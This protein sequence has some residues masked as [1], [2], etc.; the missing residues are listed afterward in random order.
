MTEHPFVPLIDVEL[1]DA[2]RDPAKSDRGPSA[3]TM[4]KW[5]AAA[6]QLH[7]AS[8]SSPEFYADAA[9]FAVDAI[10][11][12]A[13]WV[14]K[15]SPHEATTWEVLGS[16]T[17]DAIQ[18][19]NVPPA[20]L[21]I[22][23][24]QPVTWFQPAP[25]ES[26]N[27]GAAP[28]QAAVVSPVLDEGGEIAAVVY[29]V[30]STQAANRR[31]G[32]R[33]LEARLMQL[34]AESVSVGIRRLEQETAAARSRILL[35]QAFSPTVVEHLEKHPQCLTGQH[36]EVTLLFADLCSFTALAEPLSPADCY[37]LLG[38][39]METLTQ[40]VNAECGIVV[41][42]YGDGL[43]AL[44]NAPLAQ[45]EHADAACRAAL[46]MLRAFAALKKKWQP[47]LRGPLELG[48]GV[49]TGA[50][51]VGNAG[52]RTRLKYGP[53]GSTVNLAHRVQSASKQLALP[54]VVSGATQQ[55]LS[56]Q[57]FSLRICTAKLP[58]LEQPIDLFT[59]H[60]VAEAADVKSRFDRYAAALQYFE[61]GDLEHAEQMLQ[62]L[63]DDSQ[64]TP[65]RFL[66]EHTLA[67]K[68]IELGRR[69]T[70]RHTESGSPIIE[71]VKQQ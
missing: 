29:G 2:L 44:W 49:H 14:L 70:D 9:R 42:Y 61:S 50:A 10:G 71:I 32:I 57:F 39:V 16:A 40:V 53:R 68:N 37:E 52:T 55:Q 21:K 30:R 4:A 58:G 33:P 8:A 63:L 47:R 6:G 3:E 11:L 15:P 54:L 62:A 22:L 19:T 66:A 48:I 31:R 26:S 65:A 36:R 12:D 23:R 51:H 69:R 13:A 59:V 17:T 34:L 5:L 25:E 45:A 18:Q 64:T 43:L 7:R 38:D 46:A 20:L 1:I 24:N 60:P 27:H 41:D 67:Q 56:S 35:E 28:I